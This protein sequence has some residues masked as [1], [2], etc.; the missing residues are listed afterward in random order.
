MR[1]NF[2][3]SKSIFLLTA[4]LLLSS[5]LYAQ[6]AKLKTLRLDEVNLSEGLFK[7]AM[8]TDLAYILELDPDRLFA[9]YLR[10]A[11]LPTKAES[12]TNWENTGLDGHIGGH[13]LTALAQ[14]QASAHNQQADSLLNYSLSELERVQKANGNG[15]IGGVPGSKVLWEEI[16]SSDIRPQSFSLNG[17]WVPLYNI[18]K[19]FAGLRD[20][21][22]IS[23]KTKAREMLI[24][25]SDW[26]LQVTQNLTEEEIQNMLI[27][28]HGGLNEVFADVAKITG[29]E[30]YLNLA[31]QFSHQSLLQFLQNEQSEALNGMHA[32]TQIPKVI[33]FQT[34]AEIDN[35]ISYHKASEFFWNNVVNQRSVAIGGNSVR[36][37]FHLENDFS[38]MMTSEQGPE[39]CNTY[40]MI[41]LSEKL[42]LAQQDEKYIH[43]LE[44]ATYNHIL[45]SQHPTQGGFVYFT[46]MRPG[47]YR[48]YSQPQT[49]FWCCVGSGIE[50]HG[51]YNAFIYTYSENELYVNLFM[52]S[53]VNWSEKGVSIKQK[54]NFPEEE[55]TSFEV[56]T[57]SPKEF[58]FHIRYPSWVNEAEYQISVNGKPVS[59]DQNSG[60]FVRI[61]RTWKDGDYIKVNLPMRISAEFLPDDSNFIALKYGPIVLATKTGTEDLKGLFAGD[62][63]GDHIA[64]GTQFRISEMPVFL[65]ENSE[66]LIEKVNKIS[67]KRLRFS[68]ED[69][70]YPEQFS[71]WEFIPFYEIHESR[72]TIYLPLETKTSYIQKQEKRKL[73]EKEKE[74]IEALTIDR[75]A[76]G[77]QQPESDHFFESKD[78]NSGV[79]QNK[80]WRDATGWFSYKLKDKE[81]KAKKLLI[82]YY[83]KD[84]DRDFSIKINNQLL[85][86][87][88]MHGDQEEGFFTKEYILPKQ[89]DY[90]TEGQIIL[91]FEAKE[92]SRTAGIY[93]IRLLKKE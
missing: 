71:A 3:Y 65:A 78:S 92:N 45:S 43:Y 12:Y 1:H 21:Y 46:P 49:S 5:A 32:N 40:N 19:M 23:G 34:I 74:K 68:I 20:A 52:A 38:E 25:L 66:E 63:R 54:T 9:P 57:D 85:A 75:V 6:N 73:E 67:E 58:D 37:H 79:F 29:D 39:T 18:H 33:G 83:G 82:T 11:G 30:K 47:H 60:S 93:D 7:E 76:P 16:Q 28:E 36:E 51:K 24:A 26:M 88:T 44:N 84:K 91:R 81:Q 2:I 62:G 42:F 70:L 87:E 8:H 27:S 89:M 53:T 69:G 55:F 17:K 48:L 4:S 86:K 22:Q 35:N 15:Y 56:E 64:K 59:I 10:E 61:S 77:E 31:Y 50:N 14:M 13:Y 41:K 90:D 72:Y 80:H